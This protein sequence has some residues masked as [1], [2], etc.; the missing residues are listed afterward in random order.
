M[1]CQCFC[2]MTTRKCVCVFVCVYF[3]PKSTIVQSNG[4]EQNTEQ[5][6]QEFDRVA[7][8]PWGLK[9]GAK[10]EKKHSCEVKP[11]LF[12]FWFHWIQTLAHG[13]ESEDS[14]HAGRMF[15]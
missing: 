4:E 8:K 13:C 14:A 9:N 15:Q 5:I 10:G 6:H 7:L 11:A 3:P 12:F 2:H 1:G